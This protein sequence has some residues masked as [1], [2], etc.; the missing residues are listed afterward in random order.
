[1]LQHR[2]WQRK[3]GRIVAPHFQGIRGS[4]EVNEDS[5]NV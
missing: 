5:T 3:P 4:R 2:G 1:M